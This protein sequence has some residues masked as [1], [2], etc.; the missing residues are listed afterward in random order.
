MALTQARDFRDECDALY[1]VLATAPRA[2]WRQPTQFKQ[3]TFDDIVGH[4]Y[5][6]DRAAAIAA[7]SREELQ[8]LFGELATAARA[9]VSMIDYSRR[10]LA[11]CS[12]SDLL[13]RWQDQYVALEALY[14]ELDPNL[15][16]AWAGPD[17]SA[18]SFMS[19]RQMEAWAHGQAVFDAL[20][21]ERTEHD[22]IRNIAVMGINTFGWAFAVNGLEVPDL[23]PYV[24][25]V[26]P[27][28]AVWEWHD[29]GAV[30]RVEGMAVD[31]CRVV[32]Q[33]RNVRDTGL[34]V[35]GPVARQWLD[36]AQCFSGPRETPPPPGTRH[37]Q[38]RGAALVEKR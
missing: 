24:R 12:G 15:R 11:G 26:S 29:A 4:L 3:W 34:Q 30:E 7:R 14:A 25:L 10:W 32:T 19:A 2:A 22:R 18:R 17:M 28:G 35:T 8:A 13:A 9:G 23:R 37:V 20:G 6:F 33:T 1:A 27:S 38:D 36:I 21:C 5:F 16:L 31:F